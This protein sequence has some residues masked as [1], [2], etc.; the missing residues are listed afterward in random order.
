MIQ[1]GGQQAIQE[2]RGSGWYRSGG[3]K[4]DTGGEGQRVKMIREGRACL[5]REGRGTT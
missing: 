4:L 2:G 5:I 3:A 1:E